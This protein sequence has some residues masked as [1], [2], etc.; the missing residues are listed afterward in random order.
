MYKTHHVRDPNLLYTTKA[1]ASKGV[2]TIQS[3]INVEDGSLY[4]AIAL[5]NPKDEF[6][7]KIGSKLA[8]ERL[9][10]P[11]QY[12]RK[13]DISINPKNNSKLINQYI[14]LDILL[15]IQCPNWAKYIIE[16]QLLVD[17]Y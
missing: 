12:T 10:N 13:L 1:S 2:I 14:Y 15:N 4:Y 17:N 7:K 16:Q 8:K 6:N 3:Y 5:C 9:S 11:G